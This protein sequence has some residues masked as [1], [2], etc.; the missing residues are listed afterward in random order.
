MKGLYEIEPGMRFQHTYTERTMFLAQWEFCWI[1]QLCPGCICIQE[2]GKNGEIKYSV[3]RWMIKQFILWSNS[4]VMERDY[5]GQ[6]PW[7]KVKNF[8]ETFWYC[9]C[10][11]TPTYKMKNR[12][13]TF[14]DDE[15]QRNVYWVIILDFI[16]IILSP[17]F[18]SVISPFINCL[19]SI[20]FNVLLVIYAW[21][22]GFFG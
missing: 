16:E 14:D 22:F 10:N 4:I 8:S 17:F 7:F 2:W 18:I 3:G 13:L 1:L 21:S 6:I 9:S 15:T 12:C 11:E 19:F 5:N 20:Y